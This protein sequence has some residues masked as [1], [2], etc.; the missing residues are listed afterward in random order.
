MAEG[1]GAASSHGGPGSFAAFKTSV[2]RRFQ[3]VSNTMESIQGLSAWCIENKKHHGLI[4]RYWM[5][6]LRKS[7]ATHRLNLFY[8][9]NDVIQNCRRKNAIIYRTSFAEVLPAAVLLVRDSKVRKSME[10]ILA[11]WMER[12]IYPEEFISDLEASLASKAA[13]AALVNNKASLKAKVVAEFVPNAFRQQLSVYKRSLEEAELKEKQLSALGMDICSTEAFKKLKD[14]AGGK[15]FSK[16]FEDTSKKFQDFVGFMEQQVKEERP[17][18]EALSNADMFYEMQYKEVKIIAKAYMSFASRVSKVKQKLDNLKSTLPSLYDS[19]VPSPC[20][21]APSPA[22]SE[23]PIHTI[24]CEGVENMS[25]TAVH[26]GTEL[27][28]TLTVSHGDWDNRNVE[29][30]DLS[31][32]EE[33]ETT[34]IIV[35]EQ[36]K[37]EVPVA[38]GEADSVH[39]QVPAVSETANSQQ[40][41]K[42]PMLPLPLDLAHV[43]LAKI[44]SILSN[45]TSVMKGTR[46][47]NPPLSRPALEASNPGEPAPASLLSQ[48]DTSPQ[49]LLS[50][51]SNIQG[52]AAELH[53]TLSHQQGVTESTPSLADA[54]D[55]TSA[56]PPEGRDLH[57]AFCTMEAISPGCTM[58]EPKLFMGNN[59]NSLNRLGM[60]EACS[61]SSPSASL[62]DKIS[63]FLQGNPLFGS[64][65]G[66]ANNLGVVLGS[67]SPCTATER[68]D[69]TPLRDEA[70]GTPTQDEVVVES[71][72][73]L[74]RDH[75]N[76]TG[77]VRARPLST[78]SSWCLPPQPL[79]YQSVKPWVTSLS[80][81][82][83]PPMDSL[84]GSHHERVGGGMQSSGSKAAWAL[85]NGSEDKANLG[86][87]NAWNSEWP[88]KDV[89]SYSENSNRSPP[90][91]SG[92]VNLGSSSSAQAPLQSGLPLAQ[93]S[94]G[95]RPAL[96]PG[97]GPPHHPSPFNFLNTPLPLIPQLPPPRKDFATP[98]S[99]AV[100]G[101]TV[102]PDCAAPALPSR[103][104]KREPAGGYNI[105]LPKPLPPWVGR[106]VGPNSKTPPLSHA[107]P[108]APAWSGEPSTHPPEHIRPRHPRSSHHSSAGYRSQLQPPLHQPHPVQSHPPP[109]RDHHTPLAIPPRFSGGSRR[110]PSDP[111]FCPTKR[112]FLPPYN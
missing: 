25:S 4:V 91:N 23:S 107:P 20:E 98:P 86:V 75:C 90:G 103:A 12:K 68:V 85:M 66:S 57:E 22:G 109:F 47:A 16:D 29:D 80:Y 62:E 13:P 14:K 26:R 49:G 89:S 88:L 48:V 78:E 60:G 27:G 3:G 76:S 43:D 58:S 54:L 28:Q 45:L 24:S 81:G 40:P 19:P 35:E 31:E 92:S 55:S 82:E 32:G 34:D 64:L 106:G 108:S 72:V 95:G 69:G 21:D 46:A 65:N 8:L 53:A 11:I 33:T 52:Q 51:L 39:S 1:P 111:P 36:A 17:L 9:A 41:S 67:S 56:L 38:V 42:T 101:G 73:G 77:P 10:R 112:P 59:P 2:E 87:G 100:A 30:M 104:E 94:P 37:P 84:G 96:Y 83:R 110:V 74:G 71:V 18:L 93:V 70:G 44:N 105:G 102:A 99:Q 7:E 63:K 6:C 97:E 79:P 5:K 50:G 15:K 61:T